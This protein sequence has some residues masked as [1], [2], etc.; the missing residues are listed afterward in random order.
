MAPVGLRHLGQPHDDASRA[1]LRR[2]ARSQGPAALDN[3]G[4]GGYR[5]TGSGRGIRGTAM[6]ISQIHP[7]FVGEVSSIDISRKLTEP[8][9]T[10][11]RNG[12][13]RYAVLVF[14][15]QPLTD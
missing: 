8:E 1:A 14:R 9:V 13:D 2:S 5:R 10:A 7:V 6:E 12:M 11:I 3:P 4:R 15:N